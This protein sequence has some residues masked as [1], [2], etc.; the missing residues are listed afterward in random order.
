MREM[1]DV[2][3]AACL[4][5]GLFGLAAIALGVLV[6]GAVRAARLWR[7]ARH[8]AVLAVLAAVAMIVG[9]TKVTVNDPY[10]R[11]VGSYAT[12]DLLHVAV[13][14]KFDFIP[15][16][17]E[18]WIFSRLASSRNAADWT[19]LLPRHT[20]ADFPVDIFIANATNYT[21]CVAANYVP[22]P[23]VHT[24]G[25]WNI[26]GFVIPDSGGRM[27]FPNTKTA[28]RGDTE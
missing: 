3:A 2:F 17:T 8:A 24:N 16:D 14:R 10:I 1:F 4:F 7:R 6:A 23:T 15:M 26:K 20:L 21:Y 18:V 5:G 11:D 28:T 27:A 25:V 13:E 9:G 22:A 12:N 19:E